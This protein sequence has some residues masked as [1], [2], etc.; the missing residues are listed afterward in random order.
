MKNEISTIKLNV[1]ATGQMDPGL[2][3]E[4]GRQ[5]K[6]EVAKLT[7]RFDTLTTEQQKQFGQVREETLNNVQ[8]VTKDTRAVFDAIQKDI[9]GL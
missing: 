6:S 9:E 2:S 3:T 8:Q 1:V 5:L 4:Q 7:E